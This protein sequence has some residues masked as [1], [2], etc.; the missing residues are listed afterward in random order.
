MVE[1][2]YLFTEE[3]DIKCI[4]SVS[5]NDEYP[6]HVYC[7]VQLCGIYRYSLTTRRINRSRRISSND[8]NKSHYYYHDKP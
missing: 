2:T 4:P 1:E 3:A 7:V 5:D 6:I 8:I